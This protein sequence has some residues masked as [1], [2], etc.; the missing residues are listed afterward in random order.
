M[1]R[2]YKENMQKAIVAVLISLMTISFANAQTNLSKVKT[3]NEIKAMLC[4]KWKP[5]HMES[6]GQRFAIPPEMETFVT[7]KADGSLTE[8]D[9]GSTSTGK[10]TY[11]YKTRTL[12]TD[13]KDGKESHKIITITPKQLIISSQFKGITMKTIMKSV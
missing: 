8:V 6:E 3:E 10:W 11:D 9:E 7:F 2:K 13:D 12:N 5:T 4:Q 1:K